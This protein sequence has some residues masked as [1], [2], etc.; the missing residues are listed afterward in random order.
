M[1]IDIVERGL[2]SFSENTKS[3]KKDHIL[4]FFAQKGDIMFICVWV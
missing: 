2:V 1:R 3:K 4:S